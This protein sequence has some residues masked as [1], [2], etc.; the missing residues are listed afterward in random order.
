MLKTKSYIKPEEYLERERKTEFRSEYYN[1][2]MFAMSG[3]SKEHNIISTNLTWILESQLRDKPC[4]V[5]HSNL[6]VK[7]NPSGLYTYPDIIVVCG[8][9]KFE[10]E[11]LDTLLNPTLLIEILSDSTEDYDRGTKF[12]NYRQIDSLKEYVLV[13]QDKIKIEKYIRQGESNWL[14]TEE[15][16]SEKIIELPSVGCFL[17]FK[18]VYRNILPA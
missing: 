17:V 13:S 16:N 12:V 14:L 8:E 11:E 4:Q 1:G 10:D 3:A 7:V 18:E 15:S 6:R 5:F 9:Q 2:E